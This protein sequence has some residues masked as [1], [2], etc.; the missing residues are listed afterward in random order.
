LAEYRSTVPAR[1]I[2]CSLLSS[3][4]LVKHRL[5]PYTAAPGTKKAAFR[6]KAAELVEKFMEIRGTSATTHPSPAAAGIHEM[7]E[8]SGL[9]DFKAVTI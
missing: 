4:L 1:S 3:V 8:N 2:D 5:N 9:I 7:D 6:I